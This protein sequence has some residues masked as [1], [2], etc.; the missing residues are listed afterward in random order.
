MV[1]YNL[2]EIIALVTSV[3]IG[4]GA[5]IGFVNLKKRNAINMRFIVS[6]FF[7]NLF[8]TL[9]V[10]EFLKSRNLGSIRAYTLPLVAYLGQYLL[11]WLDKRYLKI[12]DGGFKKG[13]GIDLNKN[14]KYDSESQNEN[15]EQNNNNEMGGIK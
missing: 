15:Y 1:I 11:D 5:Y 14:E 8:V 3:F 6:V 13:T 2:N 12:F 10:S 4:T 7:I 9:T